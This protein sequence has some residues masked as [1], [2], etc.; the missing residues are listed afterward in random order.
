MFG[1]RWCFP[2]PGD[3]G[4]DGRLRVQVSV[5]GHPDTE[6]MTN[7]G[8][9]GRGPSRVLAPMLSAAAALS[10]QPLAQALAELLPLVISEARQQRLRDFVQEVI[11]EV[12]PEELL[13]RVQREP[14]IADLFTDAART[15][16]DTDLERKRRALARVLRLG[17]FTS[18]DAEID[19]ERMYLRAIAPLEI[20]HLRLLD[21]MRQPPQ[22]ADG[23][24][25]GVGTPLSEELL[26]GFYP[27]AGQLLRALMTQLESWGLVLDDQPASTRQASNA[28]WTATL[29]G[30]R[31]YEFLN[32]T[33]G[34]TGE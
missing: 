17:F 14:R 30:Q 8:D 3:I 23:G 4:S 20:P 11:A 28:R 2:V 10:G 5:A 29:L 1:G 22:M 31:V 13:E 19:A 32:E 25:I 6:H 15:A 12:P 33:P 7:D 24:R 27:A 18:D 16:M 9:T 34:G 21:I 26:H